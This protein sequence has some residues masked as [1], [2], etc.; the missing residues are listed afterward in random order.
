ML[1][2][3]E[4]DDSFLNQFEGLNFINR[5]KNRAEFRLKNAD[6][7]VPIILKAAIENVKLSNFQIV[8]PSLHEI[9]IDVVSKQTEKNNE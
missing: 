4:G 3:F 1:L 8:E 7:Q 2:E 5:T 9:F 6:T